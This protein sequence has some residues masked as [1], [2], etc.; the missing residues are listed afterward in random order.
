MILTY[1]CPGQ[2]CHLFF[3]LEIEFSDREVVSTS[4]AYSETVPITDLTTSRYHNE[5][6]LPCLSMW[7]ESMEWRRQV[8][9]PVTPWALENI[10]RW[11]P[12]QGLTE[13]IKRT[14]QTAPS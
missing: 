3:A 5:S 10:T 4:K 9:A 8:V 7:N 13:R 12:S 1:V 2:R 11:D 6:W 14:T